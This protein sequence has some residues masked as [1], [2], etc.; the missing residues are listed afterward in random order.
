MTFTQKT[1][2]DS[3]EPPS[4]C[5]QNKPA[6][7]T[8]ITD[9]SRVATAKHNLKINYE[10]T[11]CS[12][13]NLATQGQFTLE[14]AKLTLIYNIKQRYTHTHTHT[15]IHTCTHFPIKNQSQTD[16]DMKYVMNIGYSSCNWS[17]KSVSK[18]LI[19]WSEIN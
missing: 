10:L 9:I 19:R 12:R 16:V 7:T 17:T 2:M 8:L 4:C 15:Y 5:F 3:F 11:G 13:G 6:T 14:L 1:H 18:C